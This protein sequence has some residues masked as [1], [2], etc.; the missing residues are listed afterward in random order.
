MPFA[1]MQALA[2]A[3]RSCQKCPLAATRTTVVVG[4]GNPHAEVM[5]IGEGPGEQED[6]QGE[7]FVGRAGALLDKMLAAVGLSRQS[8]VYIANIVK[9]RP[10]QNRDPAPEEQDACI[11]WLRAQTA[12]VRPR[13]IVCLGRIAACRL[14]DPAFKVT[15]QHGEWIQKNG[16]WMM[17]MYHPAAVLRN[18]LQKPEAFGDFLKL[19]DQIHAVCPDFPWVWPHEEEGGITP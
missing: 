14:I 19:R 2:D 18:P 5:F 6:R 8:N 12:L 1:D 7:P 4:A 15:R 9:C 3:C 11:D 17:G 13:L 16:V 10:P